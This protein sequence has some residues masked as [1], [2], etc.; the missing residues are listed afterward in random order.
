LKRPLLEEENENV[1]HMI[2]EGL[3][4]QHYHRVMLSKLKMLKNTTDIIDESLT[5]IKYSTSFVLGSH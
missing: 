3:G 5:A 2:P 1:S 4:S